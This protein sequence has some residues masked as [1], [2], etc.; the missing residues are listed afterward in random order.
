VPWA[1]LPATTMSLNGWTVDKL[2]QPL[3]EDADDPHAPGTCSKNFTLLCMQAYSQRPCVPTSWRCWA[4]FRSRR[5]RL[6]SVCRMGRLDDI[7]F[8]NLILRSLPVEERPEPGTRQVRGACFSRVSPTPLE[9]PTLV[10]A[11]AD[12]LQL[13]DLDPDEV[14]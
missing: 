1:L 6:S 11:S 2:L 12:A 13:L 5:F 4:R 3:L 9:N 7:Q 8:D 14:R 10:A